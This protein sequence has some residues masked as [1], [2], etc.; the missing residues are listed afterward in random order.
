MSLVIIGTKTY[1]LRY[2][3]F[4]IQIILYLVAKL[5]WMNIGYGLIPYIT[6]VIVS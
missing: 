4:S 5:H 1:I 3:E 2:Q 6:C